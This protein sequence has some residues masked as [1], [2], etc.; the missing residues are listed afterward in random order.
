MIHML[1]VSY[2]MSLLLGIKIVGWNLGG[3]ID[4]ILY[5]IETL[6]SSLCNYVILFILNSQ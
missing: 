6:F 2:Y 3:L 4:A 5:I 1:K